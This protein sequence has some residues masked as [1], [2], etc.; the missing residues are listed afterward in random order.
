[1]IGGSAGRRCF[2]RAALH[3]PFSMCSCAIV[4][5]VP[6]STGHG[7]VIGR[8]SCGGRPEARVARR[9]YH[10]CVS[11]LIERI[12]P[13]QLQAVLVHI[14]NYGFLASQA[15]VDEIVKRLPDSAGPAGLRLRAFLL[16]RIEH[17]QPASAFDVSVSEWRQY[18][19]LTDRYVRQRPLWEIQDKL[20]L[21]ERQMRRE[22]HR[23]LLALSMLIHAHLSSA[24]SQSQA[25]ADAFEPTGQLEDAV[26]RLTPSP[27]VFGL[28]EMIEDVAQLIA[29]ARSGNWQE[30]G[31][32]SLPL[33]MTITPPTLKAHT[34]R[35]ILHQ[36]LLKLAQL[37]VWNGNADGL[38]VSAW[39]RDG[40]AHVSFEGPFTIESEQQDQ[41]YKLCQWL[42]ESLGS[43]LTHTADRVSFALPAGTQ[44]RKVLIV[45][46]EP[47]ALELFQSY[48]S[49]QNFDV[50]TESKPENALRNVTTI[51]PELVVL[52]VMMPALDGWEVL[53]RLHHMPVMRD[54]PIVACSVL[55]DAELAQ[56]LGAARFLKKP[57]LRQQLIRVLTELLPASQ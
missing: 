29:R 4:R 51:Q 8:S 19:I 21:G 30:P 35:G 18:I 27:G 40:Q 45:D 3:K 39:L 54:V 46:D 55:N 50:F 14:N 41:H 53:Q 20:S 17:M 12:S 47:S 15:I 9:C 52:D 22:H 49:G 38:C 31:A 13:E 26:Q 1:M 37:S 43:R 2:W 57:I 25:Q 16:D 34:D 28:A 42:A 33:H 6:M 7:P 48:L 5:L 23:A 10:G 11:D 24:R 36:L 44:A 32:A 56:A